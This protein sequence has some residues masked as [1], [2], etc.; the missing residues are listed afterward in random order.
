MSANDVLGII[1]AVITVI[2]GGVGA[3]ILWSYRD[4]L[5]HHK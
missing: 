3:Y 1:T 2:T 4:V 5:I